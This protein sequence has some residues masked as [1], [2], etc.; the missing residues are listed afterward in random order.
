MIGEDGAEA[1]LPLEN[2]TDNWAGL[3]AQTLVAEMEIDNVGTGGLTIE[4]QEFIINNQM[5]AEEIGRVMMQSIR[6]SA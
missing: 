3:L 4:K 1:V 2:N 6:R 5:D